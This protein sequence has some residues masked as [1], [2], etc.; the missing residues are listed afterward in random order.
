M[1]LDEYEIESIVQADVETFMSNREVQHEVKQM[2]DSGF[3]FEPYAYIACWNYEIRSFRGEQNSLYNLT[4]PKDSPYKSLR[5]LHDL[6]RANHDQI[7]FE[8]NRLY[9]L[10]YKGYPGAHIDQHQYALTEGRTEWSPYWIKFFHTYTGI[11]TSLPTLT[12]IVKLLE[13]DLMNCYVS[14][15]WPGAYLPTHRGP[16]MG[17]WKYHYGLSIPASGEMG[18]VVNNVTY[19]W[20]NGEDIMFDDSLDHSAYNFASEPRFIV[21][22]DVYREFDDPLLTKLNKR[23]HAVAGRM[24]HMMDIQ[25]RLAEDGNEF[26]PPPFTKTVIPEKEAEEELVLSVFIDRKASSSTA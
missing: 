14:I 25:R 12:R 11:S 15:L 7:L 13:D 26:E 21:L 17:T 16:T 18:I 9:H 5:R 23:L 6:I 20:K 24:D 8:V 3:T 2:I 22:A 1:A 10:G 4:P 19:H